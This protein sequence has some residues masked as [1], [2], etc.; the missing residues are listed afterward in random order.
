MR[1]RPPPRGGMTGGS[2]I[3]LLAVIAALAFSLRFSLGWRRRCFRSRR[4]SSAASRT[5]IRRCKHFIQAFRDKPRRVLNVLLLGDTIA[6]VPL[7]VL[8]LFVVWEGPLAAAELP[9]WLA[10]I[11]IFA[12]VVLLCD[13]IPKLIALSAPYRL[14][15]IGVFTLRALMPLLEGVGS[16]LETISQA[17]VGKLTP[18]Q[19]TTTGGISDEELETLL[20][21]GQEEGRLQEAEGEMIQEIIKLGDKTAKDCMTPRV[22]T[23]TLPDDLTNEEA[24]RA[25]PGEAASAHSGVRETPD[26][27]I[28]I[29]DV[30]R[31][32][33]DPSDH[34]TEHL[35]A[36]SFVPRQCAR[37]NCSAGSSRIRRDLR[38]S[39]MNSAASKASSR[40]PISWRKS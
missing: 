28:G 7:I 22:D 5:S 10:A 20:E 37:R 6:N 31:F 9:Q 18:A 3:L 29:L 15:A 30:K 12:L 21:M 24:N 13:L 1:A 4:T 32:L 11:S 8:C 38:L 36:P 19:K 27:V 16:T 25:D 17:I 39:S 14:S 34:Y 33:L 26:Q 23:F 35:I 40:A 2:L